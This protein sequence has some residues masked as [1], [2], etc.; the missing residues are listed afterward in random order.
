MTRSRLLVVRSATLPDARRR[1]PT[2]SSRPWSRA[3]TTL[4]LRTRWNYSCATLAFGPLDVLS[5][6]ETGCEERRIALADAP[7]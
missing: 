3:D 1:Q 5:I 6:F 7:G 2:E 4:L